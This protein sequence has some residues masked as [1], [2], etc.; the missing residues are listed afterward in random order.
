[1]W[2]RAL[3]L[4]DV[5]MEH[6]RM[7][8]LARRLRLSRK[9]VQLKITR[10]LRQLVQDPGLDP[11]EVI[12][13]DVLTS[14]ISPGRLELLVSRLRSIGEERHEPAPAA[15]TEF[16][17]NWTETSRVSDA[18][19][20]EMNA[21]EIELMLY[22][23]RSAISPS[24]QAPSSDD[25]PPP[26]LVSSDD[27]EPPSW[28]PVAHESAVSCCTLPAY[29]PLGV[30]PLDD[31]YKPC[32][33]YRSRKPAKMQ[34]SKIPPSPDTAFSCRQA[35]VRGKETLKNWMALRP[36]LASKLGPMQ[37]V[38]FRWYDQARDGAEIKTLH[39]VGCWVYFPLLKE[40]PPDPELTQTSTG[41]PVL[42]GRRFIEVVHGASMYTFA[43]SVINGLKPGP[44]PGKKGLRGVFVYQTLSTEKAARSSSGYVTYDAL[45]GCG[46]NIFFAPRYVL[47]VAEWRLWM[48]GGTYSAGEG[49]WALQPGTFDLRG[50]FIHIMT[51]DDL[52]QLPPESAAS[53]LWFTCSRWLP[54][55]EVKP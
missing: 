30:E 35:H 1:M 39:Q 55:Y 53:T 25:E 3:E 23:A 26:P 29:F 18:A 31:D 40:N 50:V 17:D 7:K 28:S 42:Q 8:V 6:D 41:R 2:H 47:D 22:F 5:Y 37:E 19:P 51:P 54:Q 34:M 49:Q 43:S 45:C 32:A 9:S 14:T 44:L 52:H 38:P 48:D 46:H 15:S 10:A 4:A 20:P 24:T 27:D 11:N 12:D 13:S 21:E 33:H 36:E 16:A